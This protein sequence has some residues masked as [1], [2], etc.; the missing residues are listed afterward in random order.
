MDRSRGCR[1]RGRATIKRADAEALLIKG[2]QGEDMG[3]CKESGHR[4]YT[5]QGSAE[6]YTD[7]GPAEGNIDQ[8]AAEEGEGLQ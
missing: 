8:G 2:P 7:Q 5:D 6:G 4:G 3:N 1:G